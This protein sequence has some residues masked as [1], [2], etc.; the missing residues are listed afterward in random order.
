[1]R[2]LRDIVV[3][4]A[5]L[6][7]R[8][9]E[10]V[11][12]T[13]V[14]TSGSTYRRPGARLLLSAER[15]IAGGI[16][17][18]CLERDVLSKAWWRT[19][20]GPVVVTYDSTS[21]D[22]EETW[23]FGLGCNGRVDVLL[24]RLPST[25]EAHPLDFIA[26]CLEARQ[27]GVMAT[28]FRG[29]PGVVGRRL[30]LDAEGVRTDLVPGPVRDW[31][32]AEVETVRREGRTRTAQLPSAAAP[33]EALLE[34]I[35]PPRS[36]VIFGTGQ[37]AVPLV[38]LASTLGFHLT[39]V[40]NT[41]GGAPP[42]LFQEA[43]VRL[44]ASPSVVAEKLVLEPDAAAVIMTH[45]VGHDRGYLRF[46]LESGCGYIGVLGPRART[47]RLLSEL[48]ERGFNPTEVQRASL[49]T[50]VGL[51]LGADQPEEIA[52]SI[53]SEIQ[54]RFSGADARSLRALPGP[55]HPRPS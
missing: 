46:A 17:G 12:A 24:E 19:R 26:R 27:T 30:L 32:A 11:L 7:R 22:D 47:E 31:L 40:S 51:N 20:E 54:A 9:A 15:W 36:L 2:E 29:E 8:E 1:V 16:S 53:L 28:M 43:S 42:D 48:A 33:S 50:P 52:L 44:T 4:W 21:A 14:A 25:G 5:D 35:R 45:N 41:S 37:D 49:Y 18:G 10:V 3:G 23:T 55:I 6:R 38:K 34:L 39:V 13:V